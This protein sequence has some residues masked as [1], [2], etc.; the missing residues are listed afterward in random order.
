[1]ETLR[2]LVTMLVTLA[3]VRWIQLALAQQHVL[4]SNGGL[5]HLVLRD[6][7]RSWSS[8]TRTASNAIDTAALQ[9]ILLGA[10][11]QQPESQY[12]LA[13][14]RLYGHGVEK[15][16]H[17]AVRLLRSAAEQAHRDAEFALGVLYATGGDGVVAQSDRTSA[18]WL[19]KS[20]NRGHTDAKWMLAVYVLWLYIAASHLHSRT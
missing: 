13:M 7:L 19:S 14:L 17:T 5:E 12:L 1:M 3:H 15:D 18:A 20:A 10:Q 11:Q 16:P 4:D 6:D 2:L 9:S 8:T